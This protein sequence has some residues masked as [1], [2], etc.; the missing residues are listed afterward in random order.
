MVVVVV[1]V[2]VVMVVV[3]VAA[4][5]GSDDVEGR[6]TIMGWDGRYLYAL[7]IVKYV[8]SMYEFWRE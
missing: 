8:V 3:V 2:E 6:S 1:V 5:V 4:W 7:E